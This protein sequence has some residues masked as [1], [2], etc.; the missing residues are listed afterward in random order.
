MSK[1]S[2]FLANQFVIPLWEKYKYPSFRKDLKFLQKVWGYSCN[3]LSD[4]QNQKLLR[5]VTHA[6]TNV[7]YYRE[8][9][10][11][12]WQIR[13]SKSTEELLSFFPILTRSKLNNS[14]QSLVSE[15]HPLSSLH[16]GTSSGSTGS[17]VHFFKDDS[18]EAVGKAALYFGWINTGFR[19]GNKSVTIWGNRKTVSEVWT[20]KASKIKAHMFRQHRIPACNLTSADA[21]SSAIAEIRSTTPAFMDGYTNSIFLLAREWLSLGYKHLGCAAVFTTA[22]TLL[23]SHRLVIESAFGPVF[24]QYGCSEINGIAFQ[25][26]QCG[27]YHVISPHVI[28]E[29]ESPST[30]GSCSILVTD[31]DNYAM[32]LIRYRIGDTVVPSSKVYSCTNWPSF[33]KI[34]GRISDNITLDDGTIINPISFFG[35]TLGRALSS[36]FGHSVDHQ[37]EWDGK[38]F[39]VSLILNKKTSLSKPHLAEFI[40]SIWKFDSIPVKFHEVTFI[41]PSKNGK[42]NYFINNA[43]RNV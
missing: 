26:S 16:A 25:C 36:Y 14:D 27:N 4:L 41:Q 31:L 22:E 28:V 3:D 33:N 39:N 13:K 24:D 35:D 19:F 11:P 20:T 1:W 37:T 21:V 7:P 43:P 42:R 34:A 15:R 9:E 32:P 5:L 18:A 29:Y 38:H 2:E 8:L 17:P 10:I 30:D 23:D 6:C 12:I 40:K